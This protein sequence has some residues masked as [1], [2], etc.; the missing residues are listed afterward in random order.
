MSA[1]SFSIKSSGAR[2]DLEALLARMRQRQYPETIPVLA[3]YWLKTVCA[4]DHPRGWWKE[5]NALLT[6]ALRDKRLEMPSREPLVAI[7]NWIQKSGVLTGRSAAAPPS[8][9]EPYRSSLRPE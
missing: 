3:S 8:R 7:Q 2:G 1:P 6:Q 5:L 4:A 9:V